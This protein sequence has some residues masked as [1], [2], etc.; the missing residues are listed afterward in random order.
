MTFKA[1]GVKASFE[2]EH[3]REIPRT[4]EEQGARGLRSL[5][6][7]GHILQAPCCAHWGKISRLTQREHRACRA[8]G[9]RHLS[10]GWAVPFHGLLPLHFPGK[11]QKSTWPQSFWFLPNSVTLYPF[12]TYQPATAG[13]LLHSCYWPWRGVGGFV[14]ISSPG[15]WR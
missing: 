3:S 11:Q 5:W 2:L 12:E 15:S 9:P 4:L 13:F 8:S 10:S 7:G 6:P 14:H 1:F